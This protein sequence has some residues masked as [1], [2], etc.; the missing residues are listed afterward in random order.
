MDGGLRLSAKSLAF[1]RLSVNFLFQLK[2]FS[3]V[4]KT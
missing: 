3:F 2:L 4:S 1:L